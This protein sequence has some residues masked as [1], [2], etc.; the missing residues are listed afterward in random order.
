MKRREK[1]S[2]INNEKPNL[3]VS[4][5]DATRCD[6]K[7]SQSVIHHKTKNYAWDTH[8]HTF[9]PFQWRTHLSAF[10][11]N[12]IWNNSQS[13]CMTWNGEQ[14]IRIRSLTAT[15]P[16]RFATREVTKWIKIVEAKKLMLF[17]FVVVGATSPLPL[18][19]VVCVKCVGVILF[20]Y[21]KQNM[22][23]CS[24]VQQN[25]RAM[26]IPVYLLAV[27]RDYFRELNKRTRTFIYFVVCH[28]LS[29]SSTVWK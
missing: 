12:I 15:I 8:T 13:V 27:S 22:R 7:K 23:N 24:S 29:A 28:H 26:R 17:Y 10:N 5:F 1:K 3:W 16:A 18:P 20:S 21:A 25:K 6:S 11:R 14:R 9:R 4:L 2:Y 19:L